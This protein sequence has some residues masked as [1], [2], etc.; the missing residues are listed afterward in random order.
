MTHI[1]FVEKEMNLKCESKATGNGS[2]PNKAHLKFHFV[3]HLWPFFFF[4]FSSV[5]C[6]I[7]FFWL[8]KFL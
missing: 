3:S 5:V 4:L 2:A 8:A 6:G 7:K 1:V